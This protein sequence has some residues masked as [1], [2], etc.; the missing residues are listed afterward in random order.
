MAYSRAF[1]GLACIAALLATAPV[2]A[3]DTEAPADWERGANADIAFVDVHNHDAIGARYLAA[4]PLWD[5]FR[6]RKVVLFGNVSEPAAQDTDDIA[7]QAA[8]DFPDRIVPF[9]AGVNIY[10]RKGLDYVRKQFA[11]GA[12]G[13]GEI[14][15]R[16]EYSPALAHVPWKGKHLTDG[17]LPQL[18]ELCAQYKRPVLLH[19]D[20]PTGGLEDV[21]KDFPRTTFIFGHGNAYASP[22]T[23]ERV[24]RETRNVY[25][26][27]FAGFTAFNPDSTY[28][29]DD[30][31]PL[32]RA[33]PERFLVS[34]DS[35]YGVGYENA[36]VAI[37]RLLNLLDRE[38][39]EKIAYRNFDALMA[40]AGSTAKK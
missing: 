10:S 37:R 30:Y 19:I 23:L 6:V 21:A 40:R 25:I 26:D 12:Q 24:L 5:R 20:P 8:R 18:Y 38:T 13:V 2:L 17:Q 28:S 31:L 36:Y 22:D 7:L 32:I 35:G 9:V 1:A 14:A 16:S 27:F 29:L 11:A 4:M 33:Y 39:A 34:S 15:A 3:A